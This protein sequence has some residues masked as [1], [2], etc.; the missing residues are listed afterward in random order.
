MSKNC[1]ACG[2]SLVDEA[3][4][5]E[6]VGMRVK[7]GGYLGPDL[8]KDPKLKAD[9]TRAATAGFLNIA[10]YELDR[11]YNVC[12]ACLLRALGVKPDG[13]APKGEGCMMQMACRFGDVCQLRWEKKT[14]RC[15]RFA[16]KGD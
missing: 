10:P 13:S 9:A 4:N 5:N 2:K 12:F 1:D 11:E 7:L 6:C 3:G 8:F 15:D 14:V 16:K